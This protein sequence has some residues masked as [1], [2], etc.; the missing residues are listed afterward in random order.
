MLGKI[1]LYACVRK[2]V[3]IC[4]RVTVC[5]C[6]R[7][8]AHACVCMRVCMHATVH[9]HLCGYM[10]KHVCIVQQHMSK[11]EVVKRGERG[12]ERGGRVKPWSASRDGGTKQC[13]FWKKAVIDDA[14]RGVIWVI[15]TCGM[16]NSVGVTTFSGRRTRCTL[17]P[18]QA[19][20]PHASIVEKVLAALFPSSGLAYCILH[21]LRTC[22]LHAASSHRHG[23]ACGYTLLSEK[24]AKK[25][26]N[27]SVRRADGGR[28]REGE[29]VGGRLLQQVW[30]VPA[31]L[32]RRDRKLD[33]LL[34]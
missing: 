6:M 28:G 12:P 9:V 32:P 33:G 34:I 7:A 17:I 11:E 22:M 8:Q 26:T 10:C 13:R 20:L 1:C 5:F 3:F 16:S 14:C 27:Q 15:G 18:S 21:L 29:E 24:R 31:E 23:H 2:H 25:K 4:R 30:S 19:C